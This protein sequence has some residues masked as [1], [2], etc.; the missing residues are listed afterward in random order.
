MWHRSGRRALAHKTALRLLVRG[1]L[2]KLGDGI[3]YS[4]FCSR[5][6]GVGGSTAPQQSG[7]R[8]GRP[9]PP[10]LLLSFSKYHREELKWME[11]RWEGRRFR[12]LFLLLVFRF[13]DSRLRMGA[14][15]CFYC[16]FMTQLKVSP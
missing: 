14:V 7:R 6:S 5:S 1:G 13:S 10:S 15:M 8:G 12:F 3:I 4:V 11:S 9:R 2:G 16:N